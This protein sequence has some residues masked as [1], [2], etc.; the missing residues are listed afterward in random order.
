VGKVEA[1][2][3]D[4]GLEQLRA[5]Q[6]WWFREYAH[7]QTAFDRSQYE[8][9]EFEARVSRRGLWKTGKPVPPWEWRATK[10]IK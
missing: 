8:T 5:G 7:E 6:A 3:H 9:A 4:V 1:A 10:N 2:R